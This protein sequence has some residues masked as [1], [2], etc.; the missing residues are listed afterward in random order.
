MDEH[1]SYFN[2]VERIEDAFLEID[3]DIIA[4]LSKADAEYA[5]MKKE[6][7]RLQSDFPAIS[8]IMEG[9]G[10]ISITAEE[11]AALSRYLAVKSSMEDMERKRIYFRG[12][13]DGFA[14]LKKIGAI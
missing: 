2:L 7:L 13:T 12:H 5:A 14:Y 4:D 1:D 6:I 8:K 9:K 3:N 11:H 10:A